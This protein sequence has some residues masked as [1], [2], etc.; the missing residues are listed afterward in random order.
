MLAWAGYLVSVGWLC[1]SLRQI[2]Q[3][4]IGFVAYVYVPIQYI[5]EFLHGNPGRRYVT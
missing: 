5:C 2:A 4:Y 3:L 1:R